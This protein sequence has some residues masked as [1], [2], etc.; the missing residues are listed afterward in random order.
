MMNHLKA[1]HT[2]MSPV[3]IQALKE[4]VFEDSNAHTNQSEFIRIAIA[5]KIRSDFPAKGRK[6]TD[7]D[8]YTDKR[9][10]S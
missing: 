4:I 5:E 1:V 9:R 2:K 10:K 8:I 3:M 7:A 6:L